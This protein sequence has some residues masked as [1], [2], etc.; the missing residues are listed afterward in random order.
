MP[1]KLLHGKQNVVV[2]KLVYN[3]KHCCQLLRRDEAKI[4]ILLLFIVLK[5]KHSTKQVETIKTNS[6][7]QRKNLVFKVQNS[8]MSKSHFQFLH[9]NAPLFKRRLFCFHGLK[10]VYFI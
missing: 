9:K 8:I 7:I 2:A 5:H 4:R 6:V 1:C 10:S 3:I